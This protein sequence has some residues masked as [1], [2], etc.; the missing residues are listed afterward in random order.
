MLSHQK[1]EICFLV[2]PSSPNR[3]STQIILAVAFARD[4]YSA[5]VLD[6]ET[7]AYF[8]ALQEIRLGPKKIAK[9]HVEHRSSKS[10]AQSTSEK[11]LSNVEEDF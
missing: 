7:V 5:T 1:H 10:P 9:P 4:L 3:D 8:V 2:T 6:L 11:A